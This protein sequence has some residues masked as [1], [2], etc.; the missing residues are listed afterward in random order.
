M[1]SSPIALTKANQWVNADFWI[2][3]F[4]KKG[5]GVTPGVTTAG[6]DGDL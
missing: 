5:R 1:G 2:E 4:L 3:N 6:R